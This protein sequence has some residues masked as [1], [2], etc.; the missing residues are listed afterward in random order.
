M[1]Y[2]LLALLF[3]LPASLQPTQ[4]YLGV[5][6]DQYSN[7]WNLWWTHQALFE[8]GQ[9]PYHTDLLW[10]PHGVSLW[11]HSLSELN[12]AVGAPLAGVLPLAPLFNLLVL[13]HLALAGLAAALLTRQVLGA[14]GEAPGADA[15][16]WVGGAVFAWSSFHAGHAAH[17][18]LVA[19]GALPLLLVALLRWPAAPRRWGAAAALLT[20]V[21]G[22]CSW[23]HL[24]HAGLLSGLLLGWWALRA[25]RC[26]T[27]HHVA[28]AA[29]T[30]VLPLVLLLPWLVN[31]LAAAREPQ[32]NEHDAAAFSADLL[33]WFV[34]GP[35][36]TWGAPFRGLWS[37]FPGNELELTTFVLPSAALVAWA[38]LRARRA[39]AP[40][41]FLGPLLLTGGLGFL[42]AHGP[43]LF[44]AGV[45]TG[46]PLLYA[47]LVRLVPPLRMAGV[48]L[49]FSVL[50]LLALAPLAGLAARRLSVRPWA[51][52]ALVLGV[53]LLSQAVWPF[54]AAPAQVP[55]FCRTIAADPRPVAVLDVT[56]LEQQ[57]DPLLRQTAHGK[58]LVGGYLARVP[59]ALAA[60]LKTPVV[61]QLL[62]RTRRRQLLASGVSPA[63]AE[64]LGRLSPQERAAEARDPA[65]PRLGVGWVIVAD[66]RA[67][68][69]LEE[70]GYPAQAR[71][72]TLSLHRVP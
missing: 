39:G 30:L 55:A 54:P 38:L 36:S 50:V 68:A 48:P 49:R 41:P 9:G 26:R 61:R 17:L 33:A 72:G 1:G 7:A 56:T 20:T 11:L 46:L 52:P 25:P 28:G 45:D 2:A 69:L 67:R 35:L 60:T 29:L 62:L 40:L 10:H 34:P 43:R 14:G 63:D 53:H 47:G 71:E 57:A 42:L 22:L 3:T 64:A 5:P 58:P 15:A 12:V 59:R 19:T 37:R 23:Y 21:A 13:G 51:G 44:V 70:L 27:G 65:L 31:M 8:R 66:D 24:V 4:R 6:A 16:A 18:N 32:Q